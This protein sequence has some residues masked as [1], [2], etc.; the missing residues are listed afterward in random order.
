MKFNNLREALRLFLMCWILAFQHHD[1]WDDLLQTL[2]VATILHLGCLQSSH[3]FCLL[4]LL[5]ILLLLPLEA[6]SHLKGK[7][8]PF[9][10]QSSALTGSCWHLVK[11]DSL[12]QESLCCQSSVCTAE[13]ITCRRCWHLGGGGYKKCISLHP[14]PTRNMYT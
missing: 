9:F 2:F 14:P 13:C 1:H 11:G 4:M 6:V 3:C 7:G 10:T 5:T 12:F 8:V